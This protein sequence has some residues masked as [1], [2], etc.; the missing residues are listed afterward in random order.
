MLRFLAAGVLCGVYIF[1]P[2]LFIS[3]YS[4]FHLTNTGH[5]L[6]VAS[7][8]PG[9]CL[10]PG[11]S[12]SEDERGRGLTAKTLG[13]HPL[14][15]TQMKV[16]SQPCQGHFHVGKNHFQTHCADEGE[17]AIPAGPLLNGAL[18]EICHKCTCLPMLGY[19]CQ[20]QL[21]SS[22]PLLSQL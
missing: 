11:E 16:T 2:R 13:L 12:F 22:R 5:R 20:S 3:V 1:I 6:R 15:E 9:K 19:S 17:Y 18:L 14:K 21:C 4:G 8:L 10:G 7:I